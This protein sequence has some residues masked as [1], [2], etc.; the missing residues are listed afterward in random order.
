MISQQWSGPYLPS[1]SCLLIVLEVAQ[2]PT[3]PWE[4]YFL[5]PHFTDEKTEA[6]RQ[7]LTCSKILNC[8]IYCLGDS[9]RLPGSSIS[10]WALFP[11]GGISSCPFMRPPC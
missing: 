6:L 11:R 8:T 9:L 7:E 10:G 3:T 2:S 1:I 5:V 4:V